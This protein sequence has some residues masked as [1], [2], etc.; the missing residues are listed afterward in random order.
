MLGLI[1]PLPERTLFVKLVGPA[2]T[3]RAERERFE[4]FCRSLRFEG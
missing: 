4:E 3:V 1:C 2:A